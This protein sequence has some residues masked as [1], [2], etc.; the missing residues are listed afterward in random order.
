MNEIDK[1]L[2]GK[3]FGTVPLMDEGHLELILQQM[4]K[5]DATYLLVQ[6]VNH[7]Y[8]RGAYTLGESEVLSKCIR[9][10]NQKDTENKTE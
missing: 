8:H 4:T 5:T 10:L 7:A 6:A 2:F 3:L 9:V 1:E